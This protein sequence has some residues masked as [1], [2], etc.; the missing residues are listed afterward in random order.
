MKSPRTARFENLIPL[1]QQIRPRAGVF[2][3][4]RPWR[5]YGDEIDLRVGKLL[6]RMLPTGWRFQNDPQNATLILQLVKA[7]PLPRTVSSVLRQEAYRLEIQRSQITLHAENLKGLFYG[8]QTLRQLLT[9]SDR[10]PC[11]EI[12]DWPDLEMRG[13]HLTLG[14]GHMPPYEKMRELLEK[15]AS[16][17]INYFLI[18]YDGSFSW[19]KYPFIAIPSALT[20]D[21]CRS[22]IATAKDNCLEI[23]PTVDSLGHQEHYLSHPQL[24]HLRERPD[25][26]MEL[27]ASNPKSKA[28]IK[29]LW[30]EVLEVHSDARYVNIT[31]DEVFRFNKLCPRCQKFADRGQLAD[32]FFNYYEELARWMSRQGR[33][34]MMWHDMLASHPERLADY[35]RDILVMYWN[36]WGTDA[37]KWEVTHGLPTEL[38]RSDL[39]SVPS[40]LRK[41][42]QP[43]WLHRSTKPDFTPWPYLRFFKDQ[44]FDTLGA[45]AGSPVVEEFPFAGF[46]SRIKNAKSMAQGVK[47]A[48]GR[49]LIHTYWSSF[50]SIL[51][52]WADLAAAGDYSWHTRDESTASYLKRFDSLYLGSDGKFPQAVARYE[53]Q[54]YPDR[55]PEFQ[56]TAKLPTPALENALRTF[57]KTTR[58]ACPR[59]RELLDVIA[60]SLDMAA[61]RNAAKRQS[62]EHLLPQLG[63]GKDFPIDISSACNGHTQRVIPALTG[64]NL[65]LTP[66]Q[67]RAHGVTLR[68]GNHSA[69]QGNAILLQGEY[70][71]TGATSA[72][73]NLNGKTFDRLFFFHTAAYAAPRT[74]V[75][76]YE[77]HYTDGSQ[78]V[79][80]ITA[81][82]NVGDWNM[83][84]EAPAHALVAWQGF[85]NAHDLGRRMLYLAPWINPHPERPIDRI[86]LVSTNTSGYIILVSITGRKLTSHAVKCR[87]KIRAKSLPALIRKFE[88]NYRKTYAGLCVPEHIDRALKRLNASR[89]L[90]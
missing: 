60:P 5:V 64:T 16:F 40:H 84:K 54:I 6:E 58:Q 90:P 80:P 71:P 29:D 4:A 87:L 42:Y 89:Y 7:L 69:K 20:K 88:S 74:E 79:M 35:P 81:D 45:S 62:T 47:A 53:Q 46:H 34:P 83:G 19:E 49:G 27:C 70:N 11:G 65:E 3:R 24:K 68:I 26:S 55:P 44:G 33:R 32:L 59:N 39:P 85:S 13:V 15:L 38:L 22:L 73:V 77:V 8:L 10:L 78:E 37:K 61:L 67:H 75:A 72:T 14:S 2:P 1:P 18:E 66:G 48:G 25:S 56:V 51:T 86:A 41:L 76:R 9:Q 52:A 21:Q 12:L 57:W 43:Y 17:K 23:I 36:Y 63:T 50:A 30:R 82:V 31:G 28:F